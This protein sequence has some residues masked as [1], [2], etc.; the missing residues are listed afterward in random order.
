MISFLLQF[1]ERVVSVDSV[2]NTTK[3]AT[4]TRVERTRIRIGLDPFFQ[5]RQRQ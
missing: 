4:A 2:A 5:R 3:T 1:Q